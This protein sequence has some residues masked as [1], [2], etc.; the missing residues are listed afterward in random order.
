[1]C[2][3]L[4]CIK[5]KRPPTSSQLFHPHAP[6]LHYTTPEQLYTQASLRDMV[7]DLSLESI[8]VSALW[9]HAF[10]CTRQTRDWLFK[11]SKHPQGLH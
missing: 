6:A 7:W 8:C 2:H 9:V 4:R 1:M 11:N 5:N 3:I 10:L